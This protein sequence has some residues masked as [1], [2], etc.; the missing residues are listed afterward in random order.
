MKKGV[1]KFFDSIKGFGFITKEDGRDI[2][3]HA[4][5]LIDPIENN[6]TVEFE[7]KTQNDGRDIATNVKILN[8]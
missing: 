6:D 3:V 8:G 1:V 5:G 7:V 4:T 2:Y